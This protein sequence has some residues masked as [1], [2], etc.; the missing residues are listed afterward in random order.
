MNI[1]NTKAVRSIKKLH[2]ES[3]AAFAIKNISGID[4]DTLQKFV[5][6]VN[7]TGNF[8]SVCE[9]E[10]LE[11]MR[12]FRKHIPKSCGYSLYTLAELLEISTLPQTNHTI[13]PMISTQYE[14]LFLTQLS[15]PERVLSAR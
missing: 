5:E 6:L 10:L 15:R 12:L 8:G 13:P 11:K 1:Q 14:A 3:A 2:I 9:D 7:V 4:E